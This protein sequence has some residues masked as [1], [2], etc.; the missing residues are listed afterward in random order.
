M[1]TKRVTA[2]VAAQSSGTSGTWV[3]D[4][5]SPKRIDGV[6]FEPTRTLGSVPPEALS[7]SGM[8]PHSSAQS[9]RLRPDGERRS[10][11][12]VSKAVGAEMVRRM[13]NRS[14]NSLLVAIEPLS[15]EEF[16]AGGA[17]GISVAWTVG[18]LAC[19]FDLFTSWIHANGCNLAKEVHGTFN[20]LDVKAPGGPSKADIVRESSYGRGDIVLTYRKAQIDA[21][22]LLATCSE[23]VWTMKPRGAHPDNLHTVGEIWEHLAVHTYWHMGELCGTFERFHG[24]YTLNML[25]HYFY[26]L[27][28]GE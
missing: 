2:P 7:E 25:P 5:A 8:P 6:Q 22:K 23:Q 15:Q 4:S 24:T 19:V 20:S 10:K 12:L 17:N 27:P 3:A 14:G 21:L 9:L 16:F 13:L 26:Y 18:H 11:A 28:S 1:D